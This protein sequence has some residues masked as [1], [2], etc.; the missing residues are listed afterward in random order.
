MEKKT[1]YITLGSALAV[2]AI[3][4]T[5]TLCVIYLPKNSSTEPVEHTITLDSSHI[6]YVGWN[7]EAGKCFIDLKSKEPVTPS[8]KYFGTKSELVGENYVYSSYIYAE[9]MK[10]SIGD[11]I[12]TLSVAEEETSPNV[13]FHFEFPFENDADYTSISFVGEFYKDKALSEKVNKI[14]LGADKISALTIF[15]S[16]NEYYKVVV[17][18]IIVTYKDLA[19]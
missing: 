19:K 16:S 6:N 17:D 15:E 11:N 14:T 4:V 2:A 18:R 1:L 12:F 9:N 10:T 5:T 13:E 8:G 3:A 7:E